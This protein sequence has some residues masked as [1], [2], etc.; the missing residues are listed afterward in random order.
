MNDRQLMKVFSFFF[1]EEKK[2]KTFIYLA[3]PGDQRG[4]GV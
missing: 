3:S 1:S 2:Q 4:A